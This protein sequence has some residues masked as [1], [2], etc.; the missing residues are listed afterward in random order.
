MKTMV[1]LMVAAL[2]PASAAA[3]EGVGA[4]T[5]LASYDTYERPTAYDGS[6][7][8]RWGDQDAGRHAHT[9]LLIVPPRR[10]TVFLYDGQVLIGRADR[11]ERL[12]LPAHRTYGVVAVQGSYTVWSGQVRAGGPAMEIRWFPRDR[13]PRIVQFVGWD[14]DRGNGGYGAGY[15]GGYGRPVVMASGPFHSL[16]HSLADERFDDERLVLVQSIA[17]HSYF[18]AYQA[19]QILDTFSSHEVRLAALYALRYRIVDL[20]DAE[21]LARRFP[22]YESRRQVVEMF[23]R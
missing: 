5:A 12:M 8:Y 15:G 17:P 10:G 13:T 21:P 18:T 2:A 22:Q 19:G 4:S 11:R 20:G 7:T 6:Q 3:H 14:G 23:R 16:L 1:A 9:R